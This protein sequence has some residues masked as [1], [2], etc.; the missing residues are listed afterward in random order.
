MSIDP[1]DY[2]VDYAQRMLTDT[3]QSK[4]EGG[5][6]QAAINNFLYLL[7]FAIPVFGLND[8]ISSGAYVSWRDFVSKEM[9]SLYL[10]NR[11]YYKMYL[12]SQE[13]GKLDT[14]EI[15]NPDQRICVDIA[16]FCRSFIDLFMLFFNSFVKMVSFVAILWTIE[17]WLVVFLGNR[18]HTLMVTHL[19]LKDGTVFHLTLEETR[20]KNQDS[21]IVCCILSSLSLVISQFDSISF[22]L[23]AGNRIYQFDRELQRIE[24][25][26]RFNDGPNQDHVTEESTREGTLHRRFAADRSQKKDGGGQTQTDRIRFVTSERVKLIGVTVMAPSSLKRTIILSDVNLELQGKQRLLIVGRSGIGKSSLLRVICGLWNH[27][28]GTVE[29]PELGDMLFLPQ[30]PYTPIGSLRQQL[31]YPRE[32]K[33]EEH[34]DD[35]VL[36]KV[37]ERVGLSQLVTRHGL[38]TQDLDFS[39]ILSVGEQQR[40]AIG[41]VLVIKPSVVVMDEATSA[42]DIANE[43]NVYEII[44]SLR[45]GETSII[46]VGHR[47]TLVQFHT[48]VLDL[49][50]HEKG[51]EA[52][53]TM[54]DYLKEHP[55]QQ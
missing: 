19:G 16:T 47:K 40:L 45:D 23:G 32:D 51:G 46:S 6:F 15:D 8:F 11:N 13:S 36:E 25:D 35:Q 30:K 12:R 27:G 53:R 31:L 17:P 44:G 49:D 7:I 20:I 43:K 38:R 42:M 39:K 24:N 4:D 48:H 41:R 2:A 3:L 18:L 37:L 28:R 10:R 26:Y 55:M 14:D 22:L 52:L 29:R 34:Y 9:I 5:A 54:E 50:R 21:S 33:N 1:R